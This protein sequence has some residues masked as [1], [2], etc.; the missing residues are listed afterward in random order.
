VAGVTASPSQLAWRRFARRRAALLG[1]AI[2]L[3][4]IVLSLLGAHYPALFALI[5]RLFN[6]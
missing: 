6:K 1:V 2:V 4:F 5:A 3:S